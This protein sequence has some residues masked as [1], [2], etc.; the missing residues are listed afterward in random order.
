MFYHY[1][2]FTAKQQHTFCTGVLSGG[3][4][5]IL[6]VNGTNY[7]IKVRKQHST[8]VTKLI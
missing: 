1:D 3:K 8:Y 5:N 7:Y 4:C 6:N 2:K